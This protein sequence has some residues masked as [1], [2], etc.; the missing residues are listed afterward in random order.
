MPKKDH[1]TYTIQKIYPKNEYGMSSVSNLILDHKLLCACLSI[2]EMTNY[3]KKDKKHIEE[4]M[5]FLS[6]GAGRDQCSRCELLDIC[7]V[8]L[9]KKCNM[10]EKAIKGSEE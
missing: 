7:D 1:I 2:L 6:T 9:V 5:A 4:I 3:E 10:I 8:E